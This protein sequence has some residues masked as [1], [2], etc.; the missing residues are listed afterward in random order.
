VHEV[1]DPVI[2]QPD[3]CPLIDTKMPRVLPAPGA[4]VSCAVRSRHSRA[5]SG[6]KLSTLD[7]LPVAVEM[8]LTAP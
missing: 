7:W 8:P 6:D 4:E 2:V 3:P 5:M 1:A